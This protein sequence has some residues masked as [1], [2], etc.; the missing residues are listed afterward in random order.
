[1]VL[2]VS[3]VAAAHQ[4]ALASVRPT[5]TATKKIIMAQENSTGKMMI[6]IFT[7]SEG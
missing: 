5:G 3:T 4:S 2:A 1:M 6:T 7:R